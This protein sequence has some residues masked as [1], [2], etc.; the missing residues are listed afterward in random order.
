MEWYLHMEFNSIT[1]IITKTSNTRNMAAKKSTLSITKASGVVVPFSVEKLRKSLLRSGA[2]SDSAERVIVQIQPKLYE[3]IPTKNIYRLAYGLLRGSEGVLAARYR[4]KSA[5]ME[6]GPSGFPFEQFVAEIFN[7]KGYKT[8]VGVVLQGKCVKHEIDV[9]AEKG[10][11]YYLMECKYH[12]Q[13]GIFCD[14]KVP[15]YIHS[16]VDDVVP[17]LQRLKG[18]DTKLMQA[19]VVTNT[20]FSFDAIKYGTCSGMNL[21]GWDYPVKRG[22]KDLVDSLGLYPITCLSSLS[23]AEKI[24]LMNAGIVLSREVPTQIKRLQ[25]LGMSK[26][27]IKKVLD[28][29]ETLCTEISRQTTTKRK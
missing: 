16:R 6:L 4:L 15:L 13:P 25:A 23:K 20:R 11:D 21:L 12:N 27:R 29:V 2:D 10:Q 24:A 22:I 1:Q 17:I 14:V 7:A 28:E 5:I 9:I 18:N 26:P 19:W 8:R 3:G